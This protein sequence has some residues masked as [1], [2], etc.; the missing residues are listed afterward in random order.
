MPQIIVGNQ[1]T[2]LAGSLAALRS[3]CPKNV[4][5]VRQKSAW[6]NETLCSLIVRW[7]G[8]A[9]RPHLGE[10]QPVLLLDAVR[11]HT[12]QK[13]LTACR[14]ARIWPLVI[15]AKMTWLL[16]PLDTHAF[17]SFKAYLQ[18][19]YQSARASSATGRL[20]VDRFLSCVYNA[21][22]YVLQGN[23]WA[24]SFDSDGF[25]E[26][27]MKLS[28]HVKTQ[29]QI[30]APMVIPACRPSLEQLQLCF[31]KKAAVPVE[32]LW[33]TLEP[34]ALPKLAPASAASSASGYA[35]KAP[36]VAE[37]LEARTR[38]EHRKAQQA[39]E[40]IAARSPMCAV[41]SPVARALRLPRVPAKAPPPG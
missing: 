19:A 32:A 29:L 12:A 2:F 36:P 9:L 30:E 37:I 39:K 13:V 24:L 31:P 26:N 5:L 18:E 4:I 14:G 33:R 3:A 28:S 6:N 1:S 38:S 21:I 27:Q 40:A 22:R 10:Y 7:L 11:L 17:R 8:A 23:R 35:V 41:I 34:A 25:G 20:D 15:P 16:Q